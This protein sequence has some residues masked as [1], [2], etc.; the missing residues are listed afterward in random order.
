MTRETYGRA[1]LVRG[2]CRAVMAQLAAE[3]VRVDSVVTD[4]PYELGFMGR[5]WDR[6]GVAF[7]PETWRLAYDLLPPGGHL[8]AFG[9]TRTYHRLAAAIEDAGFELRDAVAWIYGTGFPKVGYIR[10]AAG[11]PVRDGWAGSLKPAL[12][13]VALARKPLA[14]TV[15]AN[16]LEHG[17]GALNIDACRVGSEARPVMV[18]TQTVVAA[19]CMSG[20]STGATAS[21]EMTTAGRWPANVVHDGSPEVEEAFA[22][23]GERASG[24]R[25]GPRAGTSGTGYGSIQLGG[26]C[27]ASSG[28]A[29]RF[30]Y[31]AKASRAERMGSKHPTIKPAAL[32]DWLVR[33]VTPEGG[34]VLDPFAGTATIPAAAA[35]AGFRA[36][37]IES[38]P[39]HADDAARRLAA[40][41]DLFAQA[42]E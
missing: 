21:G 29:S 38:D 7:Q 11:E 41:G 37:G 23:F 9:G 20:T 8:L 2:D 19:N 18:R 5:A 12:E 17:T 1:T 3:G 42:A 33:M 22:A 35:R 40:I 6:S 36:I 26:S 31:C 30:F 16:V 28:S 4:P 32:A 15:A 39:A 13:L 14:G 25:S 34:T 27:E 10:D 24:A